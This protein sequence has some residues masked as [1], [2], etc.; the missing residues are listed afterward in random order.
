MTIWFDLDKVT[1]ESF[2]DTAP[3]RFEY[4]MHLNATAHE[5]SAP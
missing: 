5:V 4:S 3:L 1:D 2:F